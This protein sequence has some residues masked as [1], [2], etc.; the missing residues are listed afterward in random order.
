MTQRDSHAGQVIAS[1]LVAAILVMLTVAVVSSHLPLEERPH[2]D[3]KEDNS[4]HG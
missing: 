4:G 1:L 3:R 2:E